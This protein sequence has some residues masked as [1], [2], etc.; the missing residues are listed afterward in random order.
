MSVATGSAVPEPPL[1]LLA[2]PP[3]IP[4]LSSGTL[5]LL[6]GVPCEGSPIVAVHPQSKQT[7]PTERSEAARSTTTAV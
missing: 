7:V 6:S 2:L 4:P 5:P 3:T 1:P